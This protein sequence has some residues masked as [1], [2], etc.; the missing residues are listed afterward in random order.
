MQCKPR[1]E[2]VERAVADLRR[3][4]RLW[5]VAAQHGAVLVRAAETVNSL[6]A[7]A[8]R[9][10]SPARSR[11][12]CT[13]RR[14]AITG[15]ERSPAPGRCSSMS[16]DELTP[17]RLLP[18]I[19]IPAAEPGRHSA[20][21]RDGGDGV[22]S[23]RRG[24]S[25][26]SRQDRAA[27]AGFGD[28]AADVGGRGRGVGENPRPGDRG[29]DRYRRPLRQRNRMRLEAGERGSPRCRSRP[30]PTCA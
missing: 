23:Q 6:A 24:G 16:A 15:F 5:S 13:G 21:G 12:W 18:L 20:A 30:H 17:E 10:R 9:H 26:P 22:R 2:S 29:G 19:T 11:W 25:H 8:L 27:V 28:G 7:A 14:A 4:A 1:R 3:R